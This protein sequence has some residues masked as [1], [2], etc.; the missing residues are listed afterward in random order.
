MDILEKINK[1]PEEVAIYIKLFLPKKTIFLTNRKNYEENIMRIRFLF[2]SS[3]IDKRF[4]YNTETAYYSK[5]DSYINYIIKNDLH[6]VFERLIR[7]KYKH[8][9]KI[10]R[11]KYKGCMHINYLTF[12][13]HLCIT[14][15]STKCRNVIKKMEKEIP[16]LRK[17]KYKKIR[18]INNTWT[19]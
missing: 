19:N 13:N 7:Y 4:L 9:V 8:W 11:Y 5:L 18:H 1:I 12:L 3:N 16:I 2:H 6:Y 17:K 10:K 14:S 15:Q